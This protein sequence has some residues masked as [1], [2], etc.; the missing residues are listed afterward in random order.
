[1]MIGIV[2]AEAPPRQRGGPM[3]TGMV[4]QAEAHRGNEVSL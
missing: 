2:R 3:M 4:V 1:M